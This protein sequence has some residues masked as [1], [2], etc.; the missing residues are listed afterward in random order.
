MPVNNETEPCAI[1]LTA[2]PSSSSGPQRRR[3]ARPSFSPTTAVESE[4]EYEY[5]YEYESEYEYE[6][7]ERTRDAGESARKSFVRFSSD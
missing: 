6:V 7:D 1:R 2:P 5:E 4:Y 3:Y